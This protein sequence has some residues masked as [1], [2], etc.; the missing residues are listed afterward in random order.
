ML[1]HEAFD[2]TL[3]KYGISGKALSKRSGVSASHISQFRNG[4]GGAMSHTTLEV[5]LDAMEQ[6]A[7][8]SRFCFCLLFAGKNPEQSGADVLI[9]SMDDRQL[10]NL[11]L[12]VAEKLS[13]PTQQSETNEIALVAK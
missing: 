3:R 13:A 4:K 10:K 9:E 1:I 5:L 2:K 7:P 12:L 11:L 8:G 6:L